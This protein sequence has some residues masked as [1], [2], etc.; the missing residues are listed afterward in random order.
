MYMKD[1]IMSS[2]NLCP[3]PKKEGGAQ[4]LYP[5][6]VKGFKSEPTLMTAINSENNRVMVRKTNGIIAISLPVRMVYCYEKKT[7]QALRVAFQGN[8]DA[9]LSLEW[10]K[11]K[12]IC[13]RTKGIRPKIFTPNDR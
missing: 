11:A 5:V 9:A 2:E 13:S 7:F 3:D 10:R 6:V 8:D 4:G 1:V 12:P